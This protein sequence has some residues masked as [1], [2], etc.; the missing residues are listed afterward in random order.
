MFDW[1]LSNAQYHECNVQVNMVYTPFK[2]IYFSPKGQ[3]ES[4]QSNAL[5]DGRVGH[6]LTPAALLKASW[7]R[8]KGSVQRNQP[9]EA[10]WADSLEGSV[11]NGYDGSGEFK[12]T[13]PNSKR[14]W[15]FCE[16]T[17]EH[18]PWVNSLCKVGTFFRARCYG[19]HEFD[20][21]GSVQTSGWE[22]VT[23]TW[24]WRPRS[25]LPVPAP[26][27][28]KVIG[29]AVRAASLR[30]ATIFSRGF[31]TLLP[32]SGW[33]PDHSQLNVLLLL[34]VQF[35]SLSVAALWCRTVTDL[36]A[37]LERKNVGHVIKQTP[38]EADRARETAW[39]EGIKTYSSMHILKMFPNLPLAASKRSLCS[40]PV[41]DQEQDC[42][43]DCSGA[44][45]PHKSDAVVSRTGCLLE[46]EWALL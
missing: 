45:K 36:Q 2:F 15:S 14:R 18:I 33:T 39:L 19:E 13:C 27:G 11:A 6:K 3:Q 28:W 4:L 30:Y 7:D 23:Q 34:I 35:S 25:A 5:T 9:S 26:Q 44:R 16:R 40:Q 22:S 10:N 20:P 21:V 41:N 31:F 12:V 38:R 37:S 29:C 17:F 24:R 46:K 42:G 1:V 43:C 8:E 32:C